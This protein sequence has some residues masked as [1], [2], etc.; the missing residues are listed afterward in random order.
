MIAFICGFIAGFIA[1]IE[2]AGIILDWYEDKQ[3][4][5]QYFTE[6]ERRKDGHGN[7]GDLQ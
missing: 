7:T 2:A 4:I 3:M 1:G 6:K 5:D